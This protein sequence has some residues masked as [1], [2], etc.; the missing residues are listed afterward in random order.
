MGL[1]ASESPGRGQEENGL[2][3][4]VPIVRICENA[5]WSLQ[6][7]FDVFQGDKSDIERSKLE[8]R[9]SLP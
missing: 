6:Q 3:N 9:I 2:H 7:S 1:L 8:N 4:Q 5:I